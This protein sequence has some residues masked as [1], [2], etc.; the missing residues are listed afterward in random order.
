M[1]VVPGGLTPFMSQT[2]N[3]GLF[4]TLG[5]LALWLCARGA[6]GDRRAFVLGGLVVGLATLTRSDGVLLGIPF[7]IVGV[8]ELVRRMRGRDF[9]LSGTAVVGCAALFAIVMVPWVYRQ[10]EVFGSFLPSASNGRLIWLIDYQQLFSFANPPTA[11]TWFGQG[12]GAIVAS[13]L[14]GLISSLGL[15]AML[16][17]VA[18]LAPFAVIG[19]WT[20]RRDRAFQPF[21]LYAVAL[22]AVM[23]LVFPVLV[24][25]GTFIHAASALVPHTFLLV[26]G[27]VA[28]AVG[29]V[30]RRRPSWNGARATEVF[31]YGAVVL[32]VLAAALQTTSTLRSWAQVRG[33]QA[34]IAR[35]LQATP[36]ADRVMAA[37]PGAYNFLADRQGVVT[38]NDPLSVIADTMRA[39]GIRWLILE[40]ASIVPALEPVLAGE[41]RPSWLSEP[42]SV[43]PARQS[44]AT[45]AAI[46]AVCMTDA[47]T[48]CDQ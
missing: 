29:W 19:A 44:D 42:V 40:R 48:R 30:A 21:F 6:R 22:F 26:V 5:A 15:F 36:A 23:A 38:P 43:V 32:I 33:V 47:D 2:D 37:D 31:S 11:A 17:L 16:P 27:G 3:F 12:F 35:V 14:G 46:Y 8:R 45:A 1:V 25:H 34:N 10:M 24:P 28:S 20:R 4:M 7:A 41:I 13:R 39:Y 18:V 9:V